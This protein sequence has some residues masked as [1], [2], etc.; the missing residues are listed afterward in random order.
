MARTAAARSGTRFVTT[1][2]TSVRWL[3]VCRTVYSKLA[4]SVGPELILHS[5]LILRMPSSWISLPDPDV[6]DLVVDQL[7]DDT[8]ALKACSLVSHSWRISTIRW[9]F[10]SIEVQRHA[11][12]TKFLDF[13]RTSPHVAGYI[14]ELK[15]MGYGQNSPT[16]L[17][18]LWELLECVPRLHSLALVGLKLCGSAAPDSDTWPVK[19]FPAIERLSLL[20]I[21]PKSAPLTIAD[22]LPAFPN[23]HTLY[24]KPSSERF[25]PPPDA[26]AR[27]QLQLQLQELVLCWQTPSVVSWVRHTVVSCT[28]LRFYVR[29]ATVAS[30]SELIKHLAPHLTTVDIDLPD[31]SP[32]N[33]TCPPPART[34]PPHRARTVWP[35]LNLSQCPRL[36]AV[37]LYSSA[38]DGADGTWGAHAPALAGLPRG[39]R[40]L[41][42]AVHEHDVRRLP[43]AALAPL[44]ARFARLERLVLDYCR[45]FDIS[46]APSRA[47]LRERAVAGMPDLVRRGVLRVG[48]APDPEVVVPMDRPFMRGGCTWGLG[49]C[50]GC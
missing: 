11:D 18:T 48:A 19:C 29:A 21:I 20:A 3:Q 6:L 10:Y 26:D 31:G 17:D 46:G 35:A 9:L 37:A 38:A 22:V 15:L 36:A 45:D 49:F 39:L 34:A 47:L 12:W 30:L 27:T 5:L 8:K 14:K 2:I 4:L 32:P 7:Y 24:V 1:I 25:A 33:R 42:L 28:T 40:A 16:R 44:L 13:V 23:L 43:F 41:T 50:C